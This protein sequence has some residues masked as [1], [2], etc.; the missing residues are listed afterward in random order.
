LKGTPRREVLNTILMQLQ[1][2]TGQGEERAVEFAI[3]E[4]KL[5]VC[6]EVP[7]TGILGRSL[8]KF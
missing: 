5:P 4:S 7:R 2:P 8:E 3:L 6:T 1:Y